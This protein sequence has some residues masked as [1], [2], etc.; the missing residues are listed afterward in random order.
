M[1]ALADENIFDDAKVRVFELLLND[2]FQDKYWKQNKEQGSNLIE[3]FKKDRGAGDS[4]L[5][6]KFFAT[7]TAVAQELVVDFSSFFG[8]HVSFKKSNDSALPEAGPSPL[9]LAREY[10]HKCISG[11]QK[12]LVQSAKV[13]EEMIPSLQKGTN[14]KLMR[15]IA[16][17]LF[18]EIRKTYRTFMNK[19]HLEHDYYR[20]DAQ[21]RVRAYDAEL[22]GLK[23]AS[24][25]PKQKRELR[26]LLSAINELE[27]PDIQKAYERDVDLRTKTKIVQAKSVQKYVEAQLGAVEGVR[28]V[29]INVLSLFDGAAGVDDALDRVNL[30]GSA[31]VA[32]SIHY[33][34][35]YFLQNKQR[36]RQKA[37]KQKQ[38]RRTTDDVKGTHDAERETK[39]PQVWTEIIEHEFKQSMDGKMTKNVKYKEFFKD[40]DKADSNFLLSSIT[41]SSYLEFAPMPSSERAEFRKSYDISY[42]RLP[43]RLEADDL[44]LVA[45]GARE[46]IIGL[47]T[48]DPVTKDEFFSLEE[49]PLLKDPVPNR[50]VL[51]AYLLLSEVRKRES[52][53]RVAEKDLIHQ[54]FIEQYVVLWDAAKAVRDTIIKYA[55]LQQ[56]NAALILQ[57]SQKAELLRKF[58]LPIV[59][60]VLPLKDTMCQNIFSA[61]EHFAYQGPLLEIAQSSLI[62][63]K[64]NK[65][66]S[67]VQKLMGDAVKAKTASDIPFRLL[68]ENFL[69]AQ[70]S[71]LAEEKEG[72]RKFEELDQKK[73]SF[74]KIIES[75][76]DGVE[77]L[78]RDQGSMRKYCSKMLKLLQAPDCAQLSQSDLASLCEIV[79]RSHNGQ[80][81]GSETFQLDGA[82]KSGTVQNLLPT[83]CAVP[84][85]INQL[86]ESLRKY[87]TA[88]DEKLRHTN[89]DRPADPSYI[90][91]LVQ[92]ID[93]SFFERGGGVGGGNGSVPPP[94][95]MGG[96]GG[97]GSMPPPPLMNGGGGFVPP[98]P[99]LGGGGVGSNSV[100]LP[101]PHMSDGVPNL[102]PSSGGLGL[103]SR[104]LVT[105]SSLFLEEISKI[106]H[107]PF[108]KAI[109]NFKVTTSKKVFDSFL[110]EF[111]TEPNLFL[112]KITQIAQPP[113]TGGDLEYI[114]LLQNSV[115]QW[116]KI[117]SK[118]YFIADDKIKKNRG[119]DN[120]CS[121][122]HKRKKSRAF[123]S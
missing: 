60:E 103:P 18:E 86:L 100:P 102:T 12:A 30:T 35:L 64:T 5:D 81:L 54:A 123:Y 109:E 25:L 21:Q 73:A 88:L 72:V 6:A 116:T 115:M 22:Q 104:Q 98:P 43:K 66:I 45:G 28:S 48:W 57:T 65:Q 29:W 105:N 10:D 40:K 113:S 77:K 96:G 97:S 27:R 16:E 90:A 62:M 111:V 58:A 23:M 46:K 99:P 8:L 67:Q 47:F 55:L 93:K 95:P 80:N 3:S 38:G 4:A 89:A 15:E 52:Q 112:K 17:G 69:S 85:F 32:E 91:S 49:H 7:T 78:Q 26:F 75:R 108:D 1:Q 50:C 44:K 11:L 20:L 39:A 79:S 83:S 74:S 37:E 24:K 87:M 33:M 2:A 84:L 56:N 114:L 71:G 94:P 121:R 36:E 68:L 13:S 76:I 59:R 51:E 31:N 92:E 41:L 110:T 19:Y 106:M 82:D 101:P 119:K 70:V 61:S 34:R 118:E 53:F 9:P 120:E 14:L 107:K 117:T 63:R 42:S 122:C